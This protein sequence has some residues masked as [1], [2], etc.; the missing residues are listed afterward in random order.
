MPETLSVSKALESILIYQQTPKNLLALIKVYE[1]FCGPYGVHHTATTKIDEEVALAVND[2]GGPL[3]AEE[4]KRLRKEMCA[5][6]RE[7]KVAMQ[8]IRGTC[9]KQYGNLRESLAT[10]YGHGPIPGYNRQGNEFSK[11]C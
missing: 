4:K 9:Q 11:H 1:Q 2:Q 7:E 10:L 3:T 8:I 6:T 5:K